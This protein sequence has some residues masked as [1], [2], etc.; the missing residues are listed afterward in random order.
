VPSHVLIPSSDGVRVAVHDLGG[1]SDAGAPILLFSHATGFHGRVWEPVAVPLTDR[2]RCLAVDYRGHGLSETPGD[3]SLAWSRMGDDALAVLAS[4]LIA[5]GRAVHGIAHS[6]GGAALVLAAARRPGSF[7]SL[8]LYEPVIV[9]PGLLPPAHAPNPMSDGALRRRA[10]FASYDEALANFAA[11]PPLDQ[12]HPDVLRA[13]VRGGFAVQAD[14]HVVLRCA[15]AVEAAVFRGAADSG[16]WDVLPGLDLP[17]ALAT[18]RRD[19]FGPASFV[20]PAFA[21]LHTGSL[22]E[23]AHLGHFGPLEDPAGTSR[24]IVAW[25]AGSG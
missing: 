19:G 13:Y 22:V 20:A 3:A 18:G 15:P 23:R 14:G 25:V 24:D 7:R 8:W 5:P 17:V 6:M 16:A 12:L 9:G 4:E 11:K 10:S 2:Y 21:R 1:P